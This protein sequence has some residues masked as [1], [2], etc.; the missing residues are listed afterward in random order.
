MYALAWEDRGEDSPLWPTMIME[1]CQCT[2]A[3]LQSEREH[4]LIPL[5]KHQIV[6]GVSLGVDA[7]HR[8][9]IIHGDIK[10]ENVLIKITEDGMFVPK[11]A[12]FGSSIVQL[13]NDLVDIGGTDPWRAPEVGSYITLL[14]RLLLTTLYQCV[15][16]KGKISVDF[17]FETD[18]Y[19]LGLLIWRVIRNGQNPFDLLYDIDYVC[20]KTETDAEIALSPLRPEESEVS[21]GKQVLTE[22]EYIDSAVQRL[23]K[24][25]AVIQMAIDDLKYLDASDPKQLSGYKV[26]FSVYLIADPEARCEAVK[27]IG[28]ELGISSDMCETSLF[29][30]SRKENK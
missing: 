4:P 18:L 7:L 20:R 8:E 16:L 5:L 15:D 10:S 1:Y 3:E 28:K 2:L 14:L 19:S 30:L 9:D 11:L 6:A 24:S 25:N 13:Q 12:D 27:A 29:P 26:L 22:K 21:E 17:A 23:K